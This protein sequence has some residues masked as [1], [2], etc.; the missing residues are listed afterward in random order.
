M[1][2][3]VLGASGGIGRWVV[4]LAAQD[5]HVVTGLARQ[6]SEAP[7]PA[8]VVMRR[9]DVTDP[10]TLDAAVAGHD[11]VVSCLGLRRAGRSP[12]AA[13]R[14]P[15]DLTERVTRALIAAM[16]R[17]RVRRLAVVSAGGVAESL[18]RL[19]WPVRRL[20]ATANVGVAYRDLAAMERLLDS[21]TDLEW[22][23]AR[24]VTLVD[25]DPTGGAR[26]VARY[27]LAS[28]IRRADVAA[29]LL[30]AVAQP[31]VVAR[32]KVLLGS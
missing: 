31:P 3:L 32:R 7:A 12:W 21:A 29:W 9:G 11:A 19:T 4:R 13:L 5:G 18:A 27:G 14:S 26:E 15:P 8:G 2:L 17:H 25:G 22:V 1:R 23:V 6:R 16:R 20:V 10:D 28:T 30:A 24:P